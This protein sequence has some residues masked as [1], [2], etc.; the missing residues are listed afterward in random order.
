MTIRIIT[1]SILN[2]IIL[3]YA[4]LLR[5]IIPINKCGYKFKLITQTKNKKIRGRKNVGLQYKT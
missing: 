4:I 1:V 2:H 3:W 5:L